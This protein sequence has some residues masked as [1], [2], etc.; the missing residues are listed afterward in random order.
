[1]RRGEM[2]P[3]G[4]PAGETWNS[5]YSYRVR[6]AARD[7]SKDAFQPGSPERVMFAFWGGGSLSSTSLA[8]NAML[9]HRAFLRASLQNASGSYEVPS[10]ARVQRRQTRGPQCARFS[11]A[12]VGRRS[13]N[14]SKGWKYTVLIHGEISVLR[15][16]SSTGFQMTCLVGTVPPS[17]LQSILAKTSGFP[18][19]RNGTVVR[20]IP[21]SE[22]C[23]RSRDEGNL[24]RMR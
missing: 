8:G 22:Q 21:F 14:K 10:P 2:P 5:G 9:R 13:D 18:I 12:G 20:I 6:C 17:V 4:A 7:L 23:S 24:V 3:A 15:P 19:R 16:R 11:S 1:V